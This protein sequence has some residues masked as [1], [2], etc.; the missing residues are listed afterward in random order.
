MKS[1]N[2]V[3]TAVIGASML[4]V[5]LGGCTQ[6]DTAARVLADQGYTQIE[7]HGYDWFNCSKDD[8]YHD[9]FTA[10]G[11]TGRKVSGVVCGGLFFKGATVRLD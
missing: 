10:T 2:I 4:T 7:L 6:P 9:K 5:M 11:P 3:M 8:T 1:L